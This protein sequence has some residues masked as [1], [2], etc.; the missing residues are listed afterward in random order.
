MALSPVMLG[1][2]PLSL[3]LALREL[4][5]GLR[6]FRIFILCLALG[7]AS[8]AAV[9]SLSAS[10]VAGLDRDAQRLLG[11]DVELRAGPRG[12]RGV[13]QDVRNYPQ[14]TATMS[15]DGVPE[16]Q[17]GCENQRTGSGNVLFRFLVL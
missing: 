3:R 14:C 2:L 4:R 9:G 12:E 16:S 17:A 7:V 10:L 5:G 13:Q 11:G 6:G 15:T 1:Y 8:V